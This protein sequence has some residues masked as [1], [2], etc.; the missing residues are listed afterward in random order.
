MDKITIEL[1]INVRLGE[2]V[3]R[4]EKLIQVSSLFLLIWLE[5]D[6]SKK[7]GKAKYPDVW[8]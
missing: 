1:K 4:E 6:K 7:T 2:R 3:E 5:V 8:R